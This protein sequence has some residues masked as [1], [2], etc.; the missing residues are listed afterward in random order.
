[1]LC[2][3]HKC[4]FIHIP[5]TGGSSVENM[6][7]NNGESKS[8]IDC[9]LKHLTFYECKKKFGRG[10]LND[11]FKFSVVR[12]PWDRFYSYWFNSNYIQTFLSIPKKAMYDKDCVS[13]VMSELNQNHDFVKGQFAKHIAKMQTYDFSQEI[14]SQYSFLYDNDKI[15]VDYVG[16]F[17]EIDVFFDFIIN[18]FK[19][20]NKTI[21]NSKKIEGKPDYRS[22]YDRRTI[23][24]VGD[25]FKKDVRIFNYEFE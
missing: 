22:F 1:M 23:P 24:I 8:E 6:F 14:Q 2:E 20:E 3:K 18:K 13:Q 9:N 10:V 21:P 15:A 12:N 4:L 7:L 17:E 11:Y 16:R 19:F 5:K 25:M